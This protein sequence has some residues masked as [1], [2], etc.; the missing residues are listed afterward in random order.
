MAAAAESAAPREY[1][2]LLLWR[3]GRPLDLVPACRLALRRR[4]LGG[5]YVGPCVACHH[6]SCWQVACW[7]VVCGSVSRRIAD[8][9]RR[10]R[11]D[12]SAIRHGRPQSRERPKR[13]HF[14]KSYP[15]QPRLSAELR[16]RCQRY[17][18]DDE[19]DVVR[20]AVISARATGDIWNPR[21]GKR[22]LIAE[23]V[24]GSRRHIRQH[25]RL[26]LHLRRHEFQ[27]VDAGDERLL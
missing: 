6:V 26:Q 16:H 19:C 25:H 10:G 13:V 3:H 22:C 12:R 7:Q 2:P 9:V 17:A 23:F 4:A 18:F 8:R 5:C 15:R 27:R 14:L 20:V 11:S 24:A 21:G 1:G